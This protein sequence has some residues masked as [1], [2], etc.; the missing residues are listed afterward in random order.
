M[1]TKALVTATL[2]AWYL[3]AAFA[4]GWMAGGVAWWMKKRKDRRWRK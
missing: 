2:V 4:V 3:L 1:V